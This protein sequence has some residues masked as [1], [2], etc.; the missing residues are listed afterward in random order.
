M[1]TTEWENC[2]RVVLTEFAELPPCKSG[3]SDC[4]QLIT[5]YL[6]ERTGEDYLE[7]IA[8]SSEREG[9]KILAR[10]GGLVNLITERLGPPRV[11]AEAGDVAVIEREGSE[12]AAISL[13]YAF[14]TVL[15]SGGLCRVQADRVLAAWSQP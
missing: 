15:V 7:G 9:R 12:T 10:G 14:V 1:M 11:E 6:C 13:G 5:R 3:E 8:Y 4:V 2:L